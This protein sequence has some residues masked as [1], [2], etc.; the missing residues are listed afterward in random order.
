MKSA[1][2]SAFAFSALSVSAI[3]APVAIPNCSFE[4]G[5]PG[6]WNATEWTHAGVGPDQTVEIKDVSVMGRN[7]AKFVNLAVTGSSGGP[8]LSQIALFS[9]SLGSYQ[10]NTEYTLTVG[11]ANT[12]DWNSSDAMKAS[13]GLATGTDLASI[14]QVNEW[15]L[16]NDGSVGDYIPY[17]QFADK[18]FSY[19]TAAA[20]G[21]IGQNLHVVLRFT[22]DADWFKNV[23]FDNVRLDATSVPEPTSLAAFL[24]GATVLLARR[25][26]A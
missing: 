8:D 6:Y 4:T 2:F 10:A 13:I 11:I 16:R 25:R 26:K 17:N 18:S 22:H 23:I 9:A 15:S 3:A 1:L 14:L 12:H 5:A 19:T 7:G 21:P 20:G 24:T